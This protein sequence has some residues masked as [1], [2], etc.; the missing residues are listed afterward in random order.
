MLG[1]FAILS[2]KKGKNYLV[3]GLVALVALALVF[4][5]I[6][7]IRKI[8]ALSRAE[9]N[10]TVVEEELTISPN[11]AQGIADTLETAMF[12]SGTDSQSVIDT[13]QVLQTPSDFAYVVQT[14]GVR[15]NC[16]SFG[17][18]CDEGN[19]FDWFQ[20]EFYGATGSFGMMGYAGGWYY[21]HKLEAELKRLGFEL[22]D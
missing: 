5:I 8:W 4:Y 2:T 22:K 17:L 14:F 3:K 6:R 16:H 11:Q 15:E 13:L 18:F 9:S 12:E 20:Q 7:Q 1:L 10:V 19:L 21:Q